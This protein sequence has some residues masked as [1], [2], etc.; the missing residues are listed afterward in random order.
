MMP[1][2]TGVGLALTGRPIRDGP[3]RAARAENDSSRDAEKMPRG[4]PS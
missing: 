3:L 2:E 4:V 1:P